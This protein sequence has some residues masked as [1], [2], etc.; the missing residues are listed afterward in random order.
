MKE[1]SNQSF[2]E[3]GAPRREANRLYHSQKR[4]V[5][6]VFPHYVPSFGTFEY[7][8]PLTPGVKAFMPPQGLLVIAAALPRHW[9]VRFIDENMGAA[10]RA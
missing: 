5:L 10:R 3:S 8:Y 2:A 4:R 6:C 7:A 9:E 1:R